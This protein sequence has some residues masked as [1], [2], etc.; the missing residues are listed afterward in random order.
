MVTIVAADLVGYS[1]LISDDE[2]G[3]LERFKYVRET[4]IEPEL[5]SAGARVIKTMG[6]GLLVEFSSPVDAVRTSLAIQSAMVAQEA[7]QPETRKLQFRIG[8]NLGDVIIDRDDVLG[9]GVNIAARLESLAPPGGICISRTVHD[10]LRGKMSQPMTAMGPQNVKNIPEPIHVWRVEIE[11][12]SAAEA[13]A[14]KRTE[15]P[16]IVILPFDNMSSDPEQEF[17]ADGIVEDVTTELSRF[18]TLTVIARNSA[19]SF[20]GTPKDVREIA[21][22][23]DV[24]YVVEG[25]VRRAGDRLRVTAQLIEAETGGH[26]WAERWDRTMADLFD[27]QDE[28]TSA[29]VTGVEPELGAHERTLSRKK[30]TENLTAWE[31]AQRGYSKF[32]EYTQESNDAALDLYQKAMRIDPQFAFVHALAARVH[33]A[34]LALGW[35]KDFDQDRQDGLKLANRAVELDPKSDYGHVMRAGLLFLSGRHQD[36]REAL[37]ISEKLNPN[38]IVLYLIHGIA[39]FLAEEPNPDAMEAFANKALRLSPSDPQ[40]YT[41]YNL[42]GTAHLVRNSFKYNEAATNAYEMAC[43]YSNVSEVVLMNAVYACVQVDRL[44]DAKHYLETALNKA[45]YL[46]APLTMNRWSHLPWVGKL[47][48]ANEGALEKMIALGLPEE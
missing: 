21:R 19:F 44:D 3:T 38:S 31:L 41:F 22:E 25:S 7:D 1:R 13:P 33:Y 45:P 15:R 16:S 37:H 9:D 46:T 40:A 18:R 2:E 12:V 48:D 23:L 42:I 20:K 27:V 11:G 35:T 29:I 6:D 4:I 34:R 26:L 30:P 24:K 17:L 10:Q 14:T 36:A 8:I 43:R 28:L 5:K 47:H 32:F 39:E